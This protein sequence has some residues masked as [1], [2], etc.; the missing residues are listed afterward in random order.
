M[1]GKRQYQVQLFAQQE[2]CNYAVPTY[3]RELALGCAKRL[4]FS[5]HSA[6][7]ITPSGRVVWP[8]GKGK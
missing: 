4:Q 3:L 5:G 8:K 7:V 1:L 2:W 6:R